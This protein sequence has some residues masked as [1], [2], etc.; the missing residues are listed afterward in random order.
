MDVDLFFIL[1]GVYCLVAVKV[2]QWF[3]ISRLGFKS[4]TPEFFL[5][6]PQAYHWVRIALF[7]GSVAALLL[8]SAVPWYWGLA[9]LFLVWLGA[10][11]LG[12][13]LAFRTF[14]RIHREMI[15]LDESLKIADPAEYERMISDEDPEERRVALEKGARMT[16][17]ELIDRVERA[18]EW[19]I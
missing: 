2:D 1:T 15:Q 11:W 17:V 10:F 19:G 4:E 9:V 12:R 14:R 5:T 13:R 6:R 7:V 8:E 3:T 18:L 16:D